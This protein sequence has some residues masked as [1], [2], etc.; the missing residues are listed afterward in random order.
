MQTR[1]TTIGFVHVTNPGG[2]IRASLSAGPVCL[3]GRSGLCLCVYYVYFGVVVVVV[4]LY[5]V[6]SLS[7][8]IMQITIRRYPA[9]RRFPPVFPV[10]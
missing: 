5:K 6:T 3:P 7:D 1:I 9:A 4:V 8:S 10:R 2:G